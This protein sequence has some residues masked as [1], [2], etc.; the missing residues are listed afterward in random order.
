[1]IRWIRT[2]G[3]A[4]LLALGIPLAAGAQDSPGF[5]C[6]NRFGECGTPDM[7]GGGGCGCGGG[8]SILIANTDLGD[9]YQNADDYDN[10]GIEDPFDNCVRFHNADQ[11][12]GDGDGVGDSCDN[13]LAIANLG[14]LDLDG[15]GLGDHCDDDMD[16]DEILDAVDNCAAVPNPV[17]TGL[18][19]QPDMDGDGYGDACDEDIDGDSLLNLE[20]SCPMNAA[21]SE[22]SS[23]QLSA[24]FP[25]LDGDGISEID[26]LR[27]DVCPA[28]YDPEQVDLDVDGLGDACDPDR[29]GDGI[30]N[31]ADNCS[32]V[33][34]ADQVDID[35]DGRGDLCDST[36]CYVV[37]GDEDNCLDPT[38]SLD[39]YAPALLGAVGEAFRVPLFVN[40]EGQPVRYQWTVVGAPSGS[41]AT[42]ANPVG[43]SSTSV[44]H[45][46]VYEPGSEVTFTPDR[47]GEYQLQVTVSTLGADLVT[48]ELDA[49]AQHVT[50]IVA[51]GA[52]METGGG[53][54]SAAGTGAA[55]SAA[56]IFAALSFGAFG[57]RRRRQ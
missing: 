3:T 56:W 8:G 35:R 54:C 17:P 45:E 18:D 49:Q 48:G 5:E 25:D 37:F 4:S 26:P 33:V 7:S 53:G 24:C 12:D 50:T 16:G 32:G 30:L 36:Y 23:D 55:T 40:R 19:V 39:V 6:D 21:V 14:Q 29:D 27:P 46:Y 1:M 57:R 22:P 13:C 34:N 2:W 28:V 9:T 42:V 11:S 20:D 38:G 52:V 15:D 31:L 51:D 44:S 43:E 47:A 41:S 10:D